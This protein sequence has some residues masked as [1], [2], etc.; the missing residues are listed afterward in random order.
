MNARKGDR[1][2]QQLIE[3]AAVE[4]AA[5]GRKAKM[6]DVA[7]RLGLTQPA[8]YRHFKS[9]DEVHHAVVADFR[10]N[11]RELVK[12]SLIPPSVRADDLKSL[13]T[14]AVTSLLTF[15]QGNRDAMTVAMLHEPEGEKT[16]QELISMIAVNIKTEVEAGHFRQDISAEF[17]ATCLVG[18]VVQFVRHPIPTSDIQSNAELIA[19]VLFQGMQ[20]D[21]KS[22]RN[23]N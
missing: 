16:R 15:L 12:N 22:F 19:S 6:V 11:L 17:F 14:I 13:T 2:R 20:N 3:A 21:T 5:H 18:I 9:R 23:G 4:I 8:V 7:A 1:T 10:E